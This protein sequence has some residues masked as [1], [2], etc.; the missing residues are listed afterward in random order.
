M[1][2]AELVEAVATKSEV[3]K[4]D[5]EAVI[6]AVFEVISDSII[7]GEDVKI[8]GFGIFEKK[9]RAAREGTNPSNG[10]KIQIPASNSVGF[11]VSKALK[12]KLN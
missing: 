1:N 4:R 8:S 7:K 5:A 11:K 12:E 6:D 10:E 9:A 2:K 3:A